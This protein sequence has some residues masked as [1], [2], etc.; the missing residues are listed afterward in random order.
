M[1]VA[2]VTD[3]PLIT[4]FNGEKEKTSPSG[5][6][7]PEDEGRLRDTD[8]GLVPHQPFGCDPAAFNCSLAK[9]FPFQEPF[10]FH[11]FTHTQNKKP[12]SKGL[13]AL[14]LLGSEN[15]K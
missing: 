7:S 8:A 5:S 6:A 12:H 3:A 14:L 9:P 4:L 15:P 10:E 1:V 11:S 2:I 13:Y